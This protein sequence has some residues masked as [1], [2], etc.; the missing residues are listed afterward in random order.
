MGAN[1]TLGTAVTMSPA[2]LQ[3]K[4][5]TQIRD[6]WKGG[7]SH[8]RERGICSCLTTLPAQ[9]DSPEEVPSPATPRP[10]QLQQP[11]LLPREGC[12]LQTLT[13]ANPEQ[14]EA[15]ISKRT[16]AE[17]SVTMATMSCWA[18]HPGMSGQQCYTGL[19]L[20]TVENPSYL[21]K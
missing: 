14:K 11:W 16:P 20:N 7:V 15:Q 8:R 3:E 9:G 12:S 4:G 17:L 13:E 19:P 6:E 18:L 10:G 1:G 5:N 2:G 21:N